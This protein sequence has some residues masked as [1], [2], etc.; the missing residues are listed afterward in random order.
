MQNTPGGKVSGGF[1]EEHNTHTAAPTMSGLNIIYE[2]QFSRHKK[3]SS[4]G[5][6]RLASVSCD[7]ASSDNNRKGKRGREYPQLSLTL[8]RITGPTGRCWYEIRQ[9]LADLSV[10]PPGA[11]VFFCEKNS[12]GVNS[13]VRGNFFFFFEVP[14]G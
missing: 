14:P 13:K 3:D 2:K 12:P 5:S 1:S 8:P 10:F 9:K 4:W 7:H 6:L 11:G